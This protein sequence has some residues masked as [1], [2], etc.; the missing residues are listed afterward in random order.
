MSSSTMKNKNWKSVPIEEKRLPHDELLIIKYGDMKASYINFWTNGAISI[1]IWGYL[2]T[3][4][5]NMLAKFEIKC[6][7]NYCKIYILVV[8]KVLKN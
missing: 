5:L 7:I 4:S 3:Y 2:T 8:S 6:L 1:K